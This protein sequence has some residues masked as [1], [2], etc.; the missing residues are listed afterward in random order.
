[1]KPATLGLTCLLAAFVTQSGCAEVL[2][3]GADALLAT[4]TPAENAAIQQDFVDHR[5]AV[6]RGRRLTEAELTPVPRFAPPEI[7]PFEEIPPRP[8]PQVRPDPP[9]PQQGDA[10]E[11]R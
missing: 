2:D 5:T 11:P 7:D 4:P 10:E 6:P 1:M 8:E 9:V 3:L